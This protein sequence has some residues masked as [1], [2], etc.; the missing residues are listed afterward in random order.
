MTNSVSEMRRRGGWF[1]TPRARRI[2]LSAAIAGA[3]AVVSVTLIPRLGPAHELGIVPWWSLVLLFFAAE[4]Y[5]LATRDRSE[6]SA[7]SVHDACVVFALFVAPPLGLIVAQ[8]GGSVLAAAAFKSNKADRLARRIGGLALS[9]SAAVLV[10]SVFDGIGSPY[11][12]VS[13]FSA[14]LAIVCATFVA[15]GLRL[16][17]VNTGAERRTAGTSRAALV[18]A[19]GGSV[20][21]AA[22]A[23]AGL[24][25]V[26]RHDPAALL[27]VVPFAG[28]CACLAGLR[29]GAAPSRPS[30]GAVRVDACCRGRIRARSRCR[31][32]SW[33]GQ[34]AAAGGC[35]LAC[36]SPAR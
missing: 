13:W 31:R 25:L 22:I 19:L 5:S 12:P 9:T 16:L 23:L 11:G 24:E 32:A 1:G 28:L 14:T 7:L 18:L 2:G 10:F 34:A 26:R 4:S 33:V 27:L 36:P 3:A 29:L 15:H 20:A 30:A 17:A 35:R 8:V 21:S 6:S